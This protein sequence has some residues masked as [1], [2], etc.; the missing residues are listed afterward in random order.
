MNQ[1]DFARKFTDIEY[2]SKKEISSRLGIG[3]GESVWKLVDDYRERFRFALDLKKFDRL[4]FSIV[5][6]PSIMALSNTAE[7]LCS[8]MPCSLRITEFS[9]LLLTIKPLRNIVKIFRRKIFW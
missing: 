6:T 2:L 8:N 1:N 9:N 7:D 3:T 5:L 4:P